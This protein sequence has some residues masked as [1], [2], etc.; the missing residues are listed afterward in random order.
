MK[1]V[2]FSVWVALLVLVSMP[3]F[4]YDVGLHSGQ[5]VRIVSAWLKAHGG[6]YSP[7]VVSCHAKSGLCLRDTRLH[8]EDRPLMK[9]KYG[10]Q[11]DYPEFKV[12]YLFQSGGK[13]RTFHMNGK[14][15]GGFAWSQ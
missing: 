9:T 4:A 11:V 6:P 5:R 14:P 13:G 8:P 10:L 12:I 1:Y 15:A 2:S 3:A 7:N